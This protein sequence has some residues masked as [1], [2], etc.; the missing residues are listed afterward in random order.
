[1]KLT[2]ARE[3]LNAYTT[4]PQHVVPLLRGAPGV[5]KSEIVAQVAIERAAQLKTAAC[6]GCDA[7]SA[8]G[9]V[10][11]CPVLHPPAVCALC[12]SGCTQA[13]VELRDVRLALFD[14]IEIKGLPHVEGDGAKTTEWAPPAWLPTSGHGILFLDELLC[15]P[16][17]TQNAALQLIY[18]RRIHNTRLSPHFA[19]I[20]AGNTV[21]DGS[22]VTRIGGALKNR[23]AFLDIETD[24]ETWCAWAATDPTI[25]SVFVAAA[26]WRPDVFLGAGVPFKRELDAQPTPRTFT[27]VARIVHQLGNAPIKVSRL[28]E[29]IIGR[30]A[31]VELDAFLS[32]T[33][34]LDMEEILSSGR[35]PEEAEANL[36]L[37]YALSGA[38]TTQ[39]R[40]LDSLP[41][42]AQATRVDQIFAVMTQLELELQVKTLAHAGLSQRPQIVGILMQHK[43]FRNLM[44]KV[45]EAAAE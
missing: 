5:G 3:L 36:S 43:S 45:I 18:D 1:M 29:P 13:H 11:E 42:K 17:A 28:A 26:A 12:G 21:E 34:K 40:L 2:E 7:G 23:L 35:L 25:P 24:G 9:H 16:P 39:I 31:G 20:A 32:M 14:P 4:T 44:R 38:L 10:A 30:G 8:T 41:K 19:I 33:A 27:R 6:P 22:Y 37:R 15:A